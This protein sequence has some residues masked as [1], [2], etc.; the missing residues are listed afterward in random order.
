MDDKVEGCNTWKGECTGGGEKAFDDHWHGPG[1]W[2]PCGADKSVIVNVTRPDGIPS[3]NGIFIRFN[4][5]A[6]GVNFELQYF[7]EDSGNWTLVA[8]SGPFG[9]GSLDVAFSFATG[10]VR[11]ALWKIDFTDSSPICPSIIEIGFNGTC[12][13]CSTTATPACCVD[14]SV[15]VSQPDPVHGESTVR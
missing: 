13:V 9:G 4:E 10:G 5:T 1:V 12:T 11:K 7:D 3:I 14:C 8:F 6:L 15:V 2:N